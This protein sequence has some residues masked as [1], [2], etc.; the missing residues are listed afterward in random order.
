MDRWGDFWR[1]TS[2]SARRLFEENF[3]AEDVTVHA[4]GNVFAAI[5]F[6]EGLALE[7]LKPE[8]LDH[9]DRDYEL[10]IAVRAVK[11]GRTS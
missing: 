7:E 10:L 4:Y 5:A 8:E 2:L 1:F 6:L 11:A 9:S 3:S